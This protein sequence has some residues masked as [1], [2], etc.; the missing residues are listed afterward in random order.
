MKLRKNPAVLPGLVLLLGLGA[1]GLRLALYRLC[2]DDK[3]LLTPG[4]PLELGAWILTGA[5]A[6]LAVLSGGGPREKRYPAAEALGELLAAVSILLTLPESIHSLV[7]ALEVIRLALSAVACVGLGWAAVSRLRGGRPSVLCYGLA[8]LFFA[9]NV[10]CC[11]RSWVSHP[12]LQDYLFPLL[13]A[14][15]MMA[16]AYL[17][18][19]PEKFR[20]RRVV[21][22]IGGFVCMAALAKTQFV[23][24]YLGCGLWMLT[25]ADA[26]GEPL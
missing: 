23:P 21:G 17:R 6:L 1:L 3:G 24:M 11:Y 26:P 7:S 8:C 18:C 4:H 20:S 16:F 9:M 5:A 2:V 15:A 19:V 14:L 10:V 13:G 22:L 12:Q 25:N